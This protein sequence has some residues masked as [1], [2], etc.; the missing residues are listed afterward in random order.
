MFPP[1]KKLIVT[2]LVVTI[3]SLGNITLADPPQPPDNPGNGGNG[4][5]GGGAPLDGGLGILL[6]MGA[7]YG[8]KKLYEARKMKQKEIKKDVL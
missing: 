4:P 2:L 1:M 7:L 6:A 5:G 8:G 3:A